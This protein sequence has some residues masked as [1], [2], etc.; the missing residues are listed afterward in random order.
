MSVALAFA[1]FHFDL[2]KSDVNPLLRDCTCG[3]IHAPDFFVDQ[4]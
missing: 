1:L 3:G 2:G 4:T